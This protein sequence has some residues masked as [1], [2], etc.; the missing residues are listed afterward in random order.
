[1]RIKSAADDSLVMRFSS[2]LALSITYLGGMRAVAQLW[3]EFTQEMRYR[4]E[5]C[6]KIPG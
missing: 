5:R 4:V 1:M 2:L 6:I 3:A